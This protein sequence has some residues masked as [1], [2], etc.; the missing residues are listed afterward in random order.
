MTAQ[1]RNKLQDA[2]RAVRELF[3]DCVETRIRYSGKSY[4][5][6]GHELGCS[7]QTVYQLARLRNLSRESEQRSQSSPVSEEDNN[8]NQ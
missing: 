6:I 2:L 1:K 3:Y 7:E 5:A 8:V 4:A